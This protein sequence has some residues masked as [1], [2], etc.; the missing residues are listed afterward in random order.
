MGLGADGSGGPLKET[1]GRDGNHGGARRGVG[2]CGGARDCYLVAAGGGD[3][4]DGWGAAGAR[5]GKTVGRGCRMA[6]GGG[7]VSSGAVASW[8]DGG[9]V[10]GYCTPKPHPFGTVVV[11]VLVTTGTLMLSV[12]GSATP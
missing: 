2:V 7:A 6:R 5:E 10:A 3:G 12:F 11:I 1:Q 4:R 9:G 8:F